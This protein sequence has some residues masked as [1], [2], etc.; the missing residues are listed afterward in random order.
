MI[1]WWRHYGPVIGSPQRQVELFTLAVY[2]S[3][4][5]V[6]LAP[7]YLERSAARGRIIRFLGSGEV[8]SDYLT[9][10]AA[11]Q[12]REAVVDVLA[13]WLSQ[14]G[15]SSGADSWDMLALAGVERS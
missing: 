9:V 4:E 10:L 1:P 7:W 12:H 13:D 2:E 8:C 3:G 11:R 15:R 5:L 14:A 6:G